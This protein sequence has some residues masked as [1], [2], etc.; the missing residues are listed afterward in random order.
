LGTEAREGGNHD[1]ERFVVEY[2]GFTE[3]IVGDEPA[4]RSP[5]V[6]NSPHAPSTPGATQNTPTTPD[7]PQS[8]PAELG[9]LTTPSAGMTS[10]TTVEFVTPPSNLNE[11]L[12]VDND[13]DAP[14]RFCKLDHV[15]GPSLRKVWYL[16]CLMEGTCCLP[17]RKSQRRSRKLERRSASEEQWRWRW[18]RSWRTRHGLWSIFH[19]DKNPLD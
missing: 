6:A 16:G 10:S 7:A 14:A 13:D 5:A 11:F 18:S 1:A 9:R 2:S 8:A 12:D 3:Q 4:G 19:Q 17:Q 15:L